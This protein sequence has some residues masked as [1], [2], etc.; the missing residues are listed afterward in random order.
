MKQIQ[1]GGQISLFQTAV[2]NQIISEGEIQSDVIEH[3]S[4][5]SNWTS[6]NKA[7]AVFFVKYGAIC[8]SGEIAKVL[9]KLEKDKRIE[10]IRNPSLTEKGKP[11]TF[12][13]EGHGKTV[14][15]K[16]VK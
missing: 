4:Q 7:L 6:L 12:M 8:K 10:V 14:S 3:F 2:D 1:T 5:C 9:K 15:V 11:S 13:T 16:W